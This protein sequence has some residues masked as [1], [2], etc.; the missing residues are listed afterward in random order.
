MFGVTA[1]VGHGEIYD[2][3]FWEEC[4]LYNAE[5]RI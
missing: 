5:N 2:D 3:M 1:S 4:A